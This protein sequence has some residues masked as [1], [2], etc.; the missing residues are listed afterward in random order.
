MLDQVVTNLCVNARDA[1]PRGGLVTLTIDRIELD[2]AAATRLEVRA[3]SY[4][5]LS[6]SDQGEGMD[7]STRARIFE[8]FFTTKA[9]G[10]GTGL[11]LSMVYGIVR[12]SGGAVTVHSAPGE[13]AT[14][15][16]LLPVGDGV[17]LAVKL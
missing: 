5:C 12:Q 4:V 3:G 17:T 16:V 8:P 13:G 10:K 15:H 9:V 2:G 7:E 14:F 11:G 6:V 1:M